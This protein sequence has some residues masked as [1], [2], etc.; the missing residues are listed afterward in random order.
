MNSVTEPDLYSLMILG[1]LQKKG[2]VYY[3]T[4][5]VAVKKTR[6]TQGKV[7]KASRKANRGR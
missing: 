5:P 7:A 1:G 6:R 3:G 2:H 4:V